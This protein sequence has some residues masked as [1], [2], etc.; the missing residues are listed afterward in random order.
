MWM[1]ADNPGTAQAPAKAAEQDSPLEEGP[2]VSGEVNDVMTELLPWMISI[3][4][5]LG[6]VVLSLFW[7]WAVVKVDEEG[8]KGP[9]IPIARL[10][11]KPGGSL[12]KGDSVDLMKAN[13]SRE[14]TSEKVEDTGP[15]G[16]GPKI[17]VGSAGT[18][19]LIGVSGGGG[20]GGG[21]MAA[22]GVVGGAGGEIA[23][24][25]Y[26]TGGN[27]RKII[28]VVDASGSLIDTLPF[29]IKEIKKS[30][31]ELNEKQQ[32]TIIFFQSGDAVEVPPVGWKVA[33]PEMKK[34]VADWVTLDRG[35]VIPHGA[36]NPVKAINLAMRMQ[37]ELVYILSDNITGKGRYEIDKQE[38]LK[39]LDSTNKSRKI[40]INTI[41][42]LYGDPLNTLKEIAEGHGGIYTFVKEKDL[43]LR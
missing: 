15:G 31:N 6:V 36:T 37:P 9:I 3:L 19:E 1:F 13:Q 29:V 12:M 4:F 7:V 5:Y 42:F 28:Y 20:G 22:L 26:G 8:D 43:G 21:K 11:D 10:S 2:S 18:L 27:A 41:Q 25:F 38:L 33:T 23:T 14:V 34:Q 39:L 16:D 35:N 24:K 17:N 32:F 30:I 40:A